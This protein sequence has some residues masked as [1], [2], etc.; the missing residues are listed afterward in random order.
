MQRPKLEDFAS[1]DNTGKQKRHHWTV[2]AKA[3]DAYISFLLGI[4]EGRELKIPM[5]QLPIVC[6]KCEQYKN[7]LRTVNADLAVTE[8]CIK[9]LCAA[10]EV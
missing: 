10:T 7:R 9:Q 8:D 2:F 5:E 3:Q 6:E 4:I 1:S